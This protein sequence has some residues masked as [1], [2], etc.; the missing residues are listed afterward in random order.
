MSDADAEIYIGIV[1]GEM[2]AER[3]FKNFSSLV[4]HNGQ[5]IVDGSPVNGKRGLPKRLVLPLATVNIM[6]GAVT[7]E[8]TSRMNANSILK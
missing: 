3:P 4:R 5:R 8:D 1:D 6:N 2:G 7:H